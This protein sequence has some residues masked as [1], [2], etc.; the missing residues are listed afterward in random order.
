MRFA[1][2]DGLRN[3]TSAIRSSR[4]IFLVAMLGSWVISPCPST[5]NEPMREV[6]EYN[7]LVDDREAGSYELDIAT[8]EDG[9]VQVTAKAQIKITFFKVY[10]YN[11][12]LTANES[13]Q[14]GKLVTLQSK[15]DDDGKQFQVRADFREVPGQVMVNDKK[16]KSDQAAWTTT[17]WQLPPKD[18]IGGKFLLLDADTGEP[19]EAIATAPK[20]ESIDIGG[21]T[22][23]CI[24]IRITQPRVIDLWFDGKK[25]LVRQLSTEDGHPTEIRIRKLRKE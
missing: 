6:R 8:R 3:V 11:Y 7:V 19:L 13:W 24:H 18:V 15:S 20:I 23:E 5:A 4:W 14:D 25:R 9:T 10:T 1:M 21:R 22:R 16:R 12:G 2:N 17:F